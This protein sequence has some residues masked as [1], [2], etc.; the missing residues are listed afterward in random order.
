MSKHTT[1]PFEI[2]LPEEQDGKGN[3]FYLIR[4]E[5][6]TIAAVYPFDRTEDRANAQLFAAAPELLEALKEARDLI[7]EECEIYPDAPMVR[8]I[9]DAIAKAE[10]RSTSPGRT[11]QPATEPPNPTEAKD[12]A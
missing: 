2:V 12:K 9:V 4:A 1:P 5:G 10:G 8:L 11:I 6:R 3:R 7:E